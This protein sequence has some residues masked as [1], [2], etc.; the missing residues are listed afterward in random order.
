MSNLQECLKYAVGLSQNDC[1]CLESD[2]PADYN[3][4]LSGYYLDDMMD[5]I[6]LSYPAEA[7]E[8]GHGDVWSLLEQARIQGINE[9]QTGF[10]ANSLQFAG[11]SMV[12]VRTS[13]GDDKITSVFS[14]SNPWCGIVIQPSRMLRGGAMNLYGFYATMGGNQTMEL[15]IYRSDNFTTPILTQ[16]FTSSNSVK[17]YTPLMNPLQLRLYDDV[18]RAYKYYFVYERL[19]GILP[20]NNVFD[21]GCASSNKLWRD[22]LVGKGFNTS[23]LGNLNTIGDGNEVWTYGLQLDVNISCDSTQWI[24]NSNL[25]FMTNPYA[26]V[27][28]KAIQLYSINKMISYLLSSTAV[29]RITVMPKD[30]L[31]AKFNANQEQIATNMQWLGVN[32]INNAK[33]M[34]DCFT[35]P[36]D[37]V[38]KREIL[39]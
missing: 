4:S 18:G 31:I 27:M 6:P 13:I 34:S 14:V 36:V 2:R 21:C 7:S 30:G 29:N 39:V 37:N 38:F 15:K 16:P 11:Q 33:T 17:V 35:C 26:R 9:F 24:C 20:M 23:A 28:A 8:C 32:M 1:V 5:S 3:K 10:L 25:D 19:N 12:P 22:Y